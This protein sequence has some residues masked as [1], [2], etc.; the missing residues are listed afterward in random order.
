MLCHAFFEI[1]A[2]F[3]RFE[4]ASVATTQTK[5]IAINRV[6]FKISLKILIVGGVGAG[7]GEYFSELK[8]LVEGL[9]LGERV[10]FAGSQSKVAEIYSLSSVTV[11]A[12][13][14]PES[15]GRSMA[16]A[17]ALNCPVIATR[18]GGALDIVR[19]GENGYFF[20]VGDAQALAGLFAPARELK[21]DGYGYVSQ[22][23][24]LKQMVE[25]TIKV[26]ESLI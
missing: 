1:T 11:S 8:S 19:E 3:R 13:S 22:N 25:K 4:I 10:I 7:R 20:D 14:K 23:F 5:Q 16:E 18:H 9:G 21:F 2:S 17:I 26:Y 6:F 24:S 12:S 15:F